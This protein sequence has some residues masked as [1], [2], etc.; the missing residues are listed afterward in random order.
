MKRRAA[1]FFLFGASA[2]VIVGCRPSERDLMEKQWKEFEA[3]EKR[4]LEMKASGEMTR[5]WMKKMQPKK[6]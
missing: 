1:L 5:E 6:N 3:A 2:A 4:A